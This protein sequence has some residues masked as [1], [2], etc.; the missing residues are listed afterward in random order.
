[1]TPA[2]PRSFLTAGLAFTIIALAAAAMVRVDNTESEGRSRIG[3]CPLRCLRLLDHLGTVASP[4]T[5]QSDGS[6]RGARGKL[7]PS[8][9]LPIQFKTPKDLGA[10]KLLVASRGLG[11]PNFAQT[12]I[13]LVHCDEK[14]RGWIG[15]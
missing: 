14:G 3:G 6:R 2:I 11:D 7:L 4:Q 10:G 15:S 8:P 5:G 9:I 13:L 1:M 12:V